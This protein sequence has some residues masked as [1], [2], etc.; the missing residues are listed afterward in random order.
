ME[1]VIQV[2]HDFD[3]AE[4]ADDAYYASLTP[5][6][7]IDI[8]LDLVA[9]YRESLGEAARRFERVYQVVDLARS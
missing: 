1:R 8:L 3:D 9:N 7:R 6:E 5:Q 4:D 2:F